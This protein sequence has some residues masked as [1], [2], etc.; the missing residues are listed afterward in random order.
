VKYRSLAVRII[1]HNPGLMPGTQTD[2]GEGWIEYKLNN[3]NNNQEPKCYSYDPTS[4]RRLIRYL[5]GLRA[6]VIRPTL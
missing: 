5:N 3:G 2:A 1:L 4:N 6:M